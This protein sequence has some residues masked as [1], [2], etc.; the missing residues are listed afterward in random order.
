MNIKFK[1]KS[2]FIYLFTQFHNSI[3]LFK[4]KIKKTLLNGIV[5]MC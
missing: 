3:N 2:V 1:K 5:Y 4:L